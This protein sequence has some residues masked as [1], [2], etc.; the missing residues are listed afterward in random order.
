MPTVIEVHMADGSTRRC[1][2]VCHGANP[3]TKDKCACVCG[4][5]LHGVPNAHETDYETINAIRAEIELGE[6][7]SI[8]MRFGA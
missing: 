6:Y 1:D 2:G 7:D 8:Q 5:R 4:G 3:E